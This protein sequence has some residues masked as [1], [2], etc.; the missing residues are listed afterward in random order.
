MEVAEFI[1]KNYYHDDTVQ[2]VTNVRELLSH[3]GI[4]YA[5]IPDDGMMMIYMMVSDEGLRMLQEK[6]RAEE[7]TPEFSGELLKHTGNNAYVFRL[8]S[9]GIKNL[10]ELRRL[11]SSIMRRHN[12]ASFSW[13]D[14]HQ[15]LLHTYRP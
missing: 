6:T 11:R 1:A 10:S 8:V 15:V 3:P 2:G 5:G 9:T 14:D 13:H 12:A 7:F 4:Y